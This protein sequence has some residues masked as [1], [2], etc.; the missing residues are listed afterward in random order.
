[1]IDLEKGRFKSSWVCR[2]YTNKERNHE[3]SFWIFKG[4]H[5]PDH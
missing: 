4:E 3:E 1:M 2:E 5:G